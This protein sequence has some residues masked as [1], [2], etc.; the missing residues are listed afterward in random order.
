M[1]TLTLLEDKDLITPDLWC[2]PLEPTYEDSGSF[3]RDSPYGSPLNN[4]KWIKARYVF[5]KVWMGKPVN[6][7]PEIEFVKGEIPK[8]HQ[9]NEDEYIKIF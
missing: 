3:F 4:M 2:R 9:L 1:K 5:G 8:S 7:F 6:S